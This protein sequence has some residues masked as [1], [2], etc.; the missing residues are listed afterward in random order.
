MIV[1]GPA[2]VRAVRDELGFDPGRVGGLACRRSRTSPPQAAGGAW[3]PPSTG[4]GP[5]TE[6]GRVDLGGAMSTNRSERNTASTAA[7]SAGDRA[8]AWRRGSRSGSADGWRD[9][10]QQGQLGDRLI[11]Q[12]P[13]CPCCGR[14]RAGPTALR[15]LE[16]RTS[17]VG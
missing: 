9:T 2:L 12:D 15:G 4:S 5:C 11:E 13:A 7:A 14:S 3:W 16:L 10:H 6:Q 17:P 8:R 1:L